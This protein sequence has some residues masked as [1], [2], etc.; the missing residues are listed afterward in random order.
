DSGGGKSKMTFFVTSVGSGAKGGNL[1]GV[2]GGD[3]MCKDLAGKVGG[4]DHTWAAYLSDQNTDAKDRIG[5][6]PW[7]NQKGLKFANVLDENGKAIPNKAASAFPDNDH[8]ILTG[9]NTDGTK[10]QA[11]CKD[12]SSS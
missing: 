6:G 8:D 1:G 4:G 2:A 9:T 12:W 11:R 7:A 5:K 10:N 3:T